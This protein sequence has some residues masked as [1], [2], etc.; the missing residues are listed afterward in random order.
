MLSYKMYRDN[1]MRQRDLEIL[2]LAYK[3]V[4]E[5][6]QSKR[7]NLQSIAITS[8]FK[9]KELDSLE[10]EEYLLSYEKFLEKYKCIILKDFIYKN[11]YFTPREMYIISPQYYLYYTFNVFKYCYIRY[12]RGVIDFSR[13]LFQ[14]FYSGHLEIEDNAFDGN[15]VNYDYSYQKFLVKRNSYAGSRV[16]SIDLQDFFKNIKIKKIIGKLDYGIDDK[17]I[18]FAETIANISNFLNQFSSLPQLHYSIASSLLSQ[19]YLEKFTDEVSKLLLTNKYKGFEAIR[20]VD[21]MYFKMPLYTRYK[22]ENEFLEKL[23]YILWKDDLNINS[24]KTKRYS[25]NEFIKFIEQKNNYPYESIQEASQPANYFSKKIQ[26]KVEELVKDEGEK[27]INFFKKLSVLY[28]R[29]GIAL[30]EYY[31]LLDKYI[32]VEGGSVS[33]IFNHLMFA[34]NNFISQI[35]LSNLYCILEAP[36]FVLFNPT[37]FTVLYIKMNDYIRSR[38]CNKDFLE[39]LVELVSTEL[40]LKRAII[41]SNMYIQKNTYWRFINQLNKLREINNNYVDFI[42]EYVSKQEKRFLY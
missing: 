14:V 8:Y 28:D 19:V 21:D 3:Y 10:K 42:D 29:Q 31:D 39:N 38:G 12:G 11:D 25:K 27:L 20:Y 13:E 26:S 16:L 4:K 36:T 34:K 40:D 18:S 24:K 37:Q 30:K 5:V 17:D 9:K 7:Y 23:S 22:K 32:E 1:M 15:K 35:G 2:D 6:A 33:K 41:I